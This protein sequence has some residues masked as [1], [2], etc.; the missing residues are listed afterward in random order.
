MAPT[1]PPPS[2]P[3]AS[4]AARRAGR[5]RPPA[6]RGRNRPVLASAGLVLSLW[7]LVACA[8]AQG[9]AGASGPTVTVAAAGDIACDPSN[10]NFNGGA[11]TGSA[12]Q[13]GATAEAVAALAPDAVLVLGDNQYEQG[14]RAQYDVSYAP[15]WGAF[16]A[17]TYPV[18]GNHEYYTSG[19]AGYYDYFGNRAGDPT[20]GYYSFDLGAWHVVAL[21][22][23]CAKVGGCDAG[24][25]QEQWL[26]ADLAAHP[27]RCTL[28]YWHHPRYSSGNHGDD[29]AM[30][31]I[32]QALADA[33]ADVV[34]S[35]HDHDYERFAPQDA[36][37]HRDDA[38][39]VRQFVV[40]TGGR[41]HYG[42]P[43]PG[44]NSQAVSDDTFGVLSMT[45]R[46]DSYDWAFAPI[47]GQSYSDSGSADCH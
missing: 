1:N 30:T 15:S 37:G 32:W 43:A 9:A 27:A 35:G 13:Q 14:T 29:A 21:N 19:A 5:E 34:L 11:G 6:A 25:P 3:G 33:G 22:S 40:G 8:G 16:M 46:P 12:C 2:E 47:A 18:P 36:H 44:P 24:S 20:K 26:R 31:D 41:S 23:N 7:A 4:L 28:A 17:N 42:L 45:L 39:G 10:G 38:A